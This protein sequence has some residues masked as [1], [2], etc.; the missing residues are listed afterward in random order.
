MKILITGATGFL[1][2]HLYESCLGDKIETIALAR[3]EK[4]WAEFQLPGKPLLG[5]LSSDSLNDWI[6]KLPDDLTHV[7]HTAGVV[8]SFNN[9]IFQEVNTVA[10][11]N[12]FEVLSKKYPKLHFVFISSL[13]A[14]GPSMDYLPHHETT[15]MNPISLYGQSKKDAED[16]LKANLPKKWSLT[17]IR[18]P[19]VIGPRDPAVLDIFKMVK[20]R[21]VLETGLGGRN[22]RYSFVCVHDVVGIIKESLKV[23]HQNLAIYFT[24]Y[25]SDH[26]FEE[27]I[28]VISEKMKKKP[29][30]LPI[31][32]AA[33][34][35][36]AHTMA[37]I[38]N[39]VKIDFRLTPDKLFELKP[40][41]W[42]C[43]GEKAT[44][45]LKYDYQWSLQDTI[46]AT[47]KDYQLRGWI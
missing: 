41:A 28:K 27:I 12:L 25:P 38:Q 21:L 1:G 39:V 43:S 37:L 11:V 4:K 2:S 7:V 18:P 6:S 20:S 10:T 22:K 46:S 13:A 15:P 19:M 31:P 14:V 44:I 30:I 17:I 16:Y 36:L 5:D 3:S 33:I 42:T 24:S 23:D 34:S 45:E 40:M 26:S 29:M 32:F 9:E 35:G 8:H 47:L